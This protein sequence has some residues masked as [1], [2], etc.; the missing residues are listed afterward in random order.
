MSIFRSVYLL[1]GALLLIVSCTPDAPTGSSSSTSYS[2]ELSKAEYDALSDEQKYQVANK[3]LATLF[4]GV[5]VDE[6]FDISNG[7]DNL[8]LKAG[9]NFLVNTKAAFEYELTQQQRNHHDLLITDQDDDRQNGVDEQRYRS[10]FRI[11]FNDSNSDWPKHLPMARIYQYPLSKN[12]LDIWITYVLTNSILFSPAEEIDSASIRD[13]QKVFFK[14]REDLRENKTI[15]QIVARH[16]RTQENWRRFRSPEDN[17]REMIEIYLGLFDRDEDVPRASKACKDLYL[18]DQDADYEL[19]STGFI[20]TEPQ[21]V[22][23]T[24]VTTCGDFYDVIAN[25]PLLIPRVTTVIVDYLFY[26]KTAD[27]KIRIVQTVMRDN[28][29]TFQDIFKSILFSRAYL[30]ENERPKSAEE[31]FFSTAHQLDWKPYRDLL[32]EMTSDNIDR[33]VSLKHMGWPVMELKLGR[34]SG[35][36]MDSLSFANYHK[37][38]REYLLLG[39]ASSDLNANN[40]SCNSNVEAVQYRNRCRWKMGLGIELPDEL[41]PLPDAAETEVTEAVLAKYAYEQTRAA[42]LSER[43]QRVLSLDL[44]D[45]LDYLF[46]SVLQ[47]K[48]SDEEKADLIAYFETRNFLTEDV[49]ENQVIRDYAY[50]EVAQ[51]VFDYVSRLPEYY[52]FLAVRE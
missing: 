42:R 41:P 17:T 24:Y 6:F 8:S 35:V 1:L 19:L 26:K 36:P 2:G 11:D 37:G 40:S 33:K 13:V 31:T 47:R 16:Q 15:R 48:A 30:L 12:T 22:L 49:L 4:K 20:N 44:D 43:S 50:D 25:H 21:Y 27:E 7:M 51:V 45:Y 39:N 28:P 9:D 46:M 23:D 3:L 34:F 5:P 29:Q 52:Y 18:S 38:V 10:L 32:M 14:L